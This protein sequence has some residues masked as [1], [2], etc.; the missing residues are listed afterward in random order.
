MPYINK[1][2]HWHNADPTGLF[3]Q[4]TGTSR[5]AELFLAAPP[6]RSCF[7]NSSTL[8]HH[9]ASDIH[10]SIHTRTER[11]KSVFHEAFGFATRGTNVAPIAG[12]T[13]WLIS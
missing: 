8:N 11:E 1:N 2:T 9:V 5:H 10:T 13:C 12:R 4:G 7:D 3:G 6:P